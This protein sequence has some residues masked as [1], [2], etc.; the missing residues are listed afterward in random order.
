MTT[1]FN[2]ANVSSFRGFDVVKGEIDIH[3]DEYKE[4]LNEIYGEVQVCGMTYSQ[5]DLLEAI[6]PVAFR[7]G[8]GDYESEIQSE[9]E[10][11]LENED[12]SEIEFIDNSE[13]EQD[14]E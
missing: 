3:T 7:C 9:L 8:L 11:A 2:I 1:K 6:D 14:E 5:G 13:E 10:E 4:F 12:D